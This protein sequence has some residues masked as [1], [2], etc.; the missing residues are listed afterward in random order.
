M[1]LNAP[2]H[3][4]TILVVDDNPSNTTL[5]AKTLDRVGYE[6]LIANDGPEA[7]QLARDELPDLILLDIVMPGEDGLSV[8]RALKDSSLTAEI[9]VIF[10]SGLDQVDT[11]LS[12]FELGAVDYI[13][14]P[15]HMQE[16]LARVR[17]HLRLA[18][19]TSSIVAQ[20]TARLAQIQAAQKALLKKPD[21]LPEA[22]FA[23]IFKPLEEAGG[24]SYEVIRISDSIFGYFL[25]DISGHDIATAYLTAATKAL[26]EQNCTPVFEPRESMAMINKVLVNLLPA[27][28]YMTACYARLNRRSQHLEVISC[29][30]PP[31]LF[32]PQ[33]GPPR[34]IESPGDVLGMFPQVAFGFSDI[35][36]KPGDRLVMYSDGLLEARGELWPEACQRLLQASGQLKAATL[37]EILSEIVELMGCA[38]VALKDD[39]VLLGLEV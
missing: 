1:A 37:P 14:K 28:K 23:V 18:L 31:A 39:L 7:R 16:V 8:M 19:A 32:L 2:E 27:D 34:L 3:G 13:T 29:G 33:D 6:V 26:L 15:F 17:L 21:D 5:L 20:Q 22:N 9:P 36:V 38:D 10:L 30:H 35:V 24:D 12:A 25:G 4:L 11:K